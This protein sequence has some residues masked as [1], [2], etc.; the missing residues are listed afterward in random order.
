MYLSEYRA[1]DDVVCVRH[2]GERV[3]EQKGG[4]EFACEENAGG[5]E[6]EGARREERKV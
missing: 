6:E 1:F 3:E 4:R 5:K 2:R